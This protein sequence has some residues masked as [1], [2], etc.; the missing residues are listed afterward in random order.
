MKDDAKFS[1]I[2]YH[3]HS[4][5]TEL[6]LTGNELLTYAII[7]SF[8]KG[9]HGVYYGSQQYLAEILGVSRRTVA[10]IY[11]K[12]FEL[13]LIEKY[14]SK[15]KRVKG[16]RAL[17]LKAETSE[18][19]ND[20]ETPEAILPPK[21]KSPKTVEEIEESLYDIEEKF[22][23]VVIPGIEILMISEQQYRKLRELVSSDV[24][25]GYARRFDK[26]MYKRMEGMLPT[27]RSHYKVLK[28]WIE[29]DFG[30]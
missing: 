28:A 9:E 2:N 4:F 21:K 16:I 26:Y 19:D 6:P 11:K 7:Y 17:V 12:L 1:S 22:T 10:R 3:I 15:T 25:Y 5:M 18:R 27:P 30:A 20:G 24:L 23:P 14:E 8:T 13:G 29:E